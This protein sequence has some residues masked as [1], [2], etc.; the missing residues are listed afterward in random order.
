MSGFLGCLEYVLEEGPRKNWFGDDVIVTCTWISA[1]CGFLFLVHAFTAK[2]PIVDLRALAIR[3]F[4]DWQSAVVHH[5]HR[6]L[7]ARCFSRRCS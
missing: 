4:G 7:R 2:E 3:N 5:G 1:I 6:H